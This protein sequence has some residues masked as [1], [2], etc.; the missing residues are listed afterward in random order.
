M[1]GGSSVL[2][3]FFKDNQTKMLLTIAAIGVVVYLAIGSW[4]N[5]IYYSEKSIHRYSMVIQQ[6][7]ERRVQMLPQFYQ[8]IQQY[9]PQAQ[10]LQQQMSK[11]YEPITQIQFT[12]Q[13]L[14]DPARMRTFSDW[15]KEIL[16]ALSSMRQQESAYPALAQNR[17]YLLLKMEL[18][19]IEQQI[20]LSTIGLN[21]E[22]LYFN[23]IVTGFPQGWINTLYPRVKPKIPLIDIAFEKNPTNYSS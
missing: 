8:L 21:R 10:T 18:Q 3:S 15:Q 16:A 11:A 5:K 6:N 12:A 23:S 20:Y 2:T 17:Q 9:A 22:I 4:L 7:C 14:T 13:T 1:L 19:N